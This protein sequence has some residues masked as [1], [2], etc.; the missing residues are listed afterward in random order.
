M[1]RLVLAA[2]LVLLATPLSAAPLARGDVP[3]PLRPWVDWVLRGH[4][5]ETCPFLHAQ[6]EKQCVWPGR[7]ELA[8]DARG[9]RFVQEL[10][11][12]AESEVPLPGAAESWPE[13]VRVDGAGA[14]VF[15]RGGRPA[16]RLARG[17]HKLEG[18]FVWSTLP[19]LL[20]IPAET[21]VVALRVGGASVP[22][23]RRDAEG[24]L[25]LRDAEAAPEPREAEDQVQ[26]K[27]HRRVV[28]EIPLLLET[29]IMLRV[30]GAARDE[31]LG[32]ALPD[33]FVPTALLGPLPARLE[34]DGRLRVQVRPGNWLFTLAAR[35]EGPV[36]SLTLPA[37]PEG[38]AG[39]P[40]RCGPSRRGRPCAWSSWRAPRPSTRPRPSCPRSGGRCR[41]IA[42]SRAAACAW[43][44]SAA[45]TR[46]AVRTSCAS[47]A[48]GISTSTAVAPPSSTGSR[49]SCAAPRGSR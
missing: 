27:V 19:P 46:A 18:R 43:S 20:V 47:P 49:A 12:A 34:P 36:A 31:Q 21:G 37:Q 14:P 16:L 48:A 38:G 33:G 10:Y 8:L 42:W 25:W 44:R 23:P 22:F 7:L 45:A 13:D 35:S 5:S 1:A 28:D 32:R 39:M 41:P 30:S 40:P 26:I 11:V 4:E 3:E 2:A 9:G 24:R 6:G 15:E 17:V 29:R